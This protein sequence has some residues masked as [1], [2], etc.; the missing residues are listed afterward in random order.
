MLSCG[1][2]SS[3]VK[4]AKRYTRRFTGMLLHQNMHA[5]RNSPVAF[6]RSD[7]YLRIFDNNAH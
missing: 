3:W 5:Q 4:H 7:L 2:Q 1:L 6:V